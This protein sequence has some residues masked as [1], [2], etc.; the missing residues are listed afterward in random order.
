MQDET[1]SQD[2]AFATENS[3]DNTFKFDEVKEETPV[4][5]Q[6]TKETEETDSI[7]KED[8][9][10]DVEQKV[11]YSRFSKI[12][13]ERDEDRNRI[14]ML[15]DT[16]EQLKQSKVA[17][18]TPEDVNVPKEWVELY[19]DSDVSKRAYQIQLQREAEL[20]EQIIEKTLERYNQNLSQ[21]EKQLEENEGIIEQGLETLQE[22]IGR[23]ITPQV[24]EKILAI[25]D[26]FSPVGKDGKYITLFPF[27]KAYE[28]YELRNAKLGQ[29]TKQARSQVASLTGNTSEGDADST[30]EPYKRG[31]DHWREAL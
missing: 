7:I 12:V 2:V 5:S 1:M 4:D 19:G 6:T 9:D 25:V 14:Q 21:Q 30:T 16:L 8:K 27:D 13:R 17:E 31:W 15:E 24:E 10:E 22:N 23:K 18:S 26:E 28:I 20:Q 11:P 3:N 29:A